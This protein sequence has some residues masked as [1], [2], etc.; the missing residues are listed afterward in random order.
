MSFISHFL[1]PQLGFNNILIAEIT[2]LRIR[3][4][5]RKLRPCSIVMANNRQMFSYSTPEISWPLEGVG[6]ESRTSLL[7]TSESPEQRLDKYKKTSSLRPKTMSLREHSVRCWNP[8]QL[9]AW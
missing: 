2:L 5:Q 3:L 4:V 7:M 8:C 1:H 6:K 9:L